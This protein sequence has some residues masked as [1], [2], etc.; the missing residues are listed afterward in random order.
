M[1]LDIKQCV[2]GRRLKSTCCRPFLD[3]K[4][5]TQLFCEGDSPENATLII[6]VPS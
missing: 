4:Q 5:G 3:V 6:P 2:V 1:K